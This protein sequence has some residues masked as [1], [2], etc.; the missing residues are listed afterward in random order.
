MK[1]LHFEVRQEPDHIGARRLSWIATGALL[2]GALGVLGSVLLGNFRPRVLVAPPPPGP[3]V[4]MLELTPIGSTE[5][6]LALRRA[7]QQ[8]LERYRYVDRDAGLAEI[9]VERAM[10]LKLSE[11][12]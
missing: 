6:G 7:Q 8:Q 10:D 12:R 11:R 2:V 9:P 5:R 3:T 1:K 4:G